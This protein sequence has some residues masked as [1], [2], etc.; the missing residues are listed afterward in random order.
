MKKKK[1]LRK[2]NIKKLKIIARKKRTISLGKYLYEDLR[3][4]QKE[5]TTIY[6]AFYSLYKSDTP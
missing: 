1:I 3:Y 6:K 2:N 5:L 4:F